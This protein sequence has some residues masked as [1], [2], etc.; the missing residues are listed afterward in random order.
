MQRYKIVDASQRLSTLAAYP[1][2]DPAM[3]H[4][5]YSAVVVIGINALYAARDPIKEGTLYIQQAPT[6]KLIVNEGELACGDLLLIPWAS[7][8]KLRKDSSDSGVFAAVDVNGDRLRFDLD[9]PDPNQYIF[10]FW[11]CRKVAD[12]SHANMKLTTVEFPVPLPKTLLPKNCMPKTMTVH[13]PI[14]KW[15]IHVKQGD[16]L[17]IFIPQKKV[18]R[19]GNAL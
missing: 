6:Q 5:L 18:Q 17:V 11:R 2:A 7:S 13:I 16:E 10:E 4:S 9:R 14:A 19:K 12:E 15:A 1:Q 8:V 3:P